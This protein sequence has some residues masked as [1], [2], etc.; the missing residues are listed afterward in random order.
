MEFSF[1]GSIADWL[2]FSLM[3]LS[4]GSPFGEAIR[5]F[6]FKA[7]DVLVLLTIVVFVAGV[8][9]SFFNRERS[10]RHLL[11]KGK[12]AGCLLASLLGVVTPFCACSAV[13][14]FIGFVTS[15]I[16][17]G[18]TTSFLV[19]SPMVNE[20]ALVMLFALFGWK[21]AALYLGAGLLVAVV[22]GW[23]IGRLRPQ[24]WVEPWVFEAASAETAG[25]AAHLT[26]TAR[27]ECGFKAVRTIVG[28]V[29]P[30]VLAGVAVG[31]VVHG[32][33]PANRLGALLGSRAWWG[34]PAAVLI[35]LPMYSNPAG[36]IPL[37]QALIEKGV[38]PGTALAFMMA[39]VGLS[40]PEAVIL[41]KVMK[42]R[43]MALFF[44]IV[45]VGIVLVGY[46]FN[47]LI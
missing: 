9:R 11:G 12:M 46:L 38:A 25:G 7:P 29:W 21:V 32:Y 4:P 41:R 31:A 44:G 33:V 8:V 27:M 2:A 22:S 19:A 13:P 3:R 1:F 5:F 14:I 36:V 24:E 26:W 18:V 35:G 47:A 39:V 23:I 43:L 17:L 37:L 28:K 45:A 16:P 6:V 15:G 34:V 20:V 40:L 42:P 10:R 30:Y